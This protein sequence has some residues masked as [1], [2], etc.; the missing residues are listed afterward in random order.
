MFIFVLHF[1][2]IQ[3]DFF[4]VSANF[5]KAAANSTYVWFS[6]LLGMKPSNKKDCV[7]LFVYKQN[8]Q[9]DKKMEWSKD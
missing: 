6:I 4:P 9:C 5:Y 8:M 1:Q 2:D 3:A 7:L